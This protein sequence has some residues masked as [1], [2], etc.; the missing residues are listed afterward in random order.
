MQTGGRNT[1]LSSKAKPRKFSENIGFC[2]VSLLGRILGC[3]HC[4][5]QQ[6]GNIDTNRRRTASHDLP[7]SG[8]LQ[9]LGRFSPR[10]RI[11]DCI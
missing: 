8:V 3:Q 6:P 5:S 10:S 9:N 1:S 11:V 2:R 7:H 4:V